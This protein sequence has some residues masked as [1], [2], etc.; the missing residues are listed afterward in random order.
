MAHELAMRTGKPLDLRL[1]LIKNLP[2]ASG[3]GGGSS[4]AAAALRALALH[5]GIESEDSRL[6]EAAATGG[7][8]VPVCL[9]GDSCY[10]TAGGTAPGPRLPHTD[11]VLV[12]PN[13]ALA[14]AGL[15][16]KAY[17][18]GGF[19]FSP[20]A[21]LEETPPDTATLVSLLKTRANDLAKPAMRAMPVIGDIIA[22]IEASADCLLARMSGSG[23]T[24]FGIYPGRD[25]AR[26]AAADILAAHPN[27]WVIQSHIPRATDRRRF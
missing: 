13:M 27:W 8:D 20:V 16:Y 5:W 14:T 9:R 1:T 3:I 21:R 25:Y 4:D 10:M 26:R 15:S 6:W 24:C 23:A 17:K 22:S 12:N 2:V 7:Q 19:A 11:I 18:E